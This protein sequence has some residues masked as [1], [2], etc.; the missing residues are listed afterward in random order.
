LSNDV[1]LPQAGMD[2]A[3]RAYAAQ[4]TEESSALSEGITGSYGVIGYRGKVWSLRYKGEKYN[5]LRPDDGT[6]AAA[7]EC[8]ILRSA[9]Q[10]SKSLYEGFDENQSDGKRPLCASLDGIVPDDEYD[11]PQSPTCAL[12]PRNNWHTNAQGKKV[13]DCTDYK[14]LAVLI[15]PALTVP[16]FGQALLEPVFLRVPAGSLQALGL[17]GEDLTR[18]GFAPYAV[19]TQVSFDPDAAHPKFVFRHKQVLSAAD[20]PVILPMIKDDQSLRI[21]GE[22]KVHQPRITHTMAKAVAGPAQPAPAMPAAPQPAAAAQGVAVRQQP[23]QQIIPPKQAPTPQP[24]S[25]PPAASGSL[26]GAAANLTAAVP[27]QATQAVVQQAATVGQPA[28][29]A[30]AQSDV[31]G[32]DPTESTP[33]LDDAINKILQMS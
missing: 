24:V 11:P 23:A 1:A 4:N 22:D 2:D 13:K 25:H 30:Q 29:A 18:Q 20:A 12:C 32:V 31:V 14:R 3:F 7:F 21:T 10:K 16:F 5:F 33:E 27:Q 28:P 15:A 26:F 17:Y 6:P 8:I 9:R 19:V